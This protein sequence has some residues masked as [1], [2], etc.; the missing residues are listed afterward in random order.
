MQLN[1]WFQKGMSYA[2]YVDQMTTNKDKMLS[3]YERYTVDEEKKAKL[4]QLKDLKLRAIG[5]TEDWCGD[6]MVNNPILMKMADEAGIE[7]HFLL[8]DQNLELMDQYLTNGTSR[9]IPK[10]IFL[11][12]AGNE[13]AV[14]GPRAPKV[15]EFVN[16]SRA[17]LPEKDAPDFEEKQKEM[18]RGIT[19]RFLQDESLW[20]E[21]SE[22]LLTI[23]EK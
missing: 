7:V 1:D 16:E 18:Y 15:Q 14:W 20:E 21:I 10:Y 4:A 17:Q 6:A 8:R 9:A 12:Q 5:L 23:L 19:K 13:Y 11:D 2:E 3:I 22:D